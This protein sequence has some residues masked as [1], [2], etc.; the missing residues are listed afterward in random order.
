MNVYEIITERIVTL[1]ESGTVPWRKPWRGDSG[2]PQ[3]LRSGKAYRG[4]NV[5]LLSC[6]PYT[7]PYWV[8]FKQAQQL[9]GSVRKGE[10]GYPVVF[11]LWR[12][13][14]TGETVDHGAS[15]RG[16]APMIRYYTVFN[17][18][19]QCDGL[20]VPT[21]PAV[22]PF[23]PIERCE[24]VVAAMPGA[25]G[26]R[27][28]GSMACYQPSVD[29]VAMP[30][31]ETFTTREMYYST[32]FH[33]LGHSTGHATRLSRPGITDPTK[34]GDHAYSREELIAEMTSAFLC[35]HCEIAPA[36]LE[37]QAAYLASWLKVLRGDSTLVV[38]AAAAAQ[39]AADW[40]LDRRPE[41]QPTASSA[42]ELA[43]EA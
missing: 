13:K 41:L 25:P 11:W 12:D 33:E 20:D 15:A 9:G 26:I 36:T 27:H 8:S 7:S 3:N 35:G 16:A 2:L 29:L 1:L 23:D 21:P 17:A 38:Q 34:F 31:R 14:Q 18:A 40:I 19:T 28:G 32:L 37:N 24:G 42:G 30:D 10:R 22:T 6:A 43:A 4:V 5:F 39:K